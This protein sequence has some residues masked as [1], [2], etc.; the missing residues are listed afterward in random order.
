MKTILQ[1]VLFVVIS[2]LAFSCETEDPIGKWDD[3]I[4]LSSK[5]LD[6]NPM[7]DSIIVTTGKAGWWLT[8]IM[9]NG[10]SYYLPQDVDIQAES[11]DL[12]TGEILVQ[13]RDNYTIFIRVQGN[14]ENYERIVSVGL[15][16]GNY[17]DRIVI[18]QEPF[19]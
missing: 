3:N 18:R 1:P 15:Q 16:N 6:F 10:E 4:H 19:E 8:N 12:E 7:G 11:Y 9:V 5:S 13:K 14:K 2:V 17:F